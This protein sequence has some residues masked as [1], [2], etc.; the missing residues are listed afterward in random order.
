MSKVLYNS[1]TGICNS[2]NV[3]RD[4]ARSPVKGEGRGGKGWGGE[5][6]RNGF[7]GVLGYSTT[8]MY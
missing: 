6:L 1:P 5:W 8:Y 3:S 7:L 4:Y 2:I